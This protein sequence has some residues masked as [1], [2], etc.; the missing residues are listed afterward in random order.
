M[1]INEAYINEFVDAIKKYES[2]SVREA[3]LKD[4][5]S[6]ICG[7][8]CE[9]NIDPTFLLDKVEWDKFTGNR[10]I[11]E[12]YI[13]CYALLNNPLINQSIE[14]L[15]LATGL[16]VVVL[17]A[18]A[19]NYINGDVIIRSA[20]LEEFLNLVKNAEYVLTTS[21][22]G[23]C[24]SIIFEKKFFAFIRKGVETRITNI[25][26][27]FHL[28]NRIVSDVSTIHCDDINY[29]EVGKVI[30]LEKQRSIEYLSRVLGIV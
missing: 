24:F 27:K 6:E 8:D 10:L 30:L 18:Q 12:K 1:K 29:E 28:E 2:I 17:N 16:K 20:G 26:E 4:Y 9:V 15:K 22:H 3:S 11:K 7:R 14:Q 21:F 25:V 19:R 5:I 23:T 13:L